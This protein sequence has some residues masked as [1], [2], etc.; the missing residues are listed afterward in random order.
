MLALRAGGVM[1]AAR[2]ALTVLAALLL[3]ASGAGAQGVESAHLPPACKAELD[4][5][6]IRLERDLMARRKALPP[7]PPGP[8]S[9]DAQLARDQAL[10]QEAY[11][12]LELMGKEIDAC[13]QRVRQQHRKPQ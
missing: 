8:K 5:R 1:S 3:A 13:V 6:L 7:L 11:A 2:T 12:R 9:S 10:M 4:A